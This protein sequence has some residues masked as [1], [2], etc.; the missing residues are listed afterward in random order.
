MEYCCDALTGSPS[1]YLDM[2][3]KQMLKLNLM[4]CVTPEITPLIVKNS[5]NKH[6]NKD[7]QESYGRG[8]NQSYHR[9]YQGRK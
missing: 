1:C 6:Q 7:Q 4:A 9:G 8:E 2:F 5:S 3:D